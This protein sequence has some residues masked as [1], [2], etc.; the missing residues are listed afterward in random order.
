MKPSSSK[1][2]RP[3]ERVARDLAA[4][5]LRCKRLKREL[6]QLEGH[7]KDYKEGCTN[8]KKSLKRCKCRVSN[9]RF[10]PNPLNDMLFGS[11]RGQVQTTGCLKCLKIDSECRCGEPLPPP[12]PPKCRRCCKIQAD[13]K[14]NTCLKCKK[15][16]KDACECEK[17]PRC[18]EAKC[19]CCAICGARSRHI[20]Y[21]SPDDVREWDGVPAWK[22]DGSPHPMGYSKDQFIFGF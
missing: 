12:P 21:C 6:N 5:K 3:K 7:A 8:C 14:C 22:T 10:G 1:R 19:I 11:L 9:E 18:K 13:C 15:M 2:P 16:P 20:C 17:C 4:A